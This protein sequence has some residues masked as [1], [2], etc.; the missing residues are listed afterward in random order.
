MFGTIPRIAAEL[1]L[2]ESFMILRLTISSNPDSAGIN[3][4]YEQDKDTINIHHRICDEKES[5]TALYQN[6]SEP[7]PNHRRNIHSFDPSDWDQV[8]IEEPSEFTIKHLQR[9]DPNRAERPVTAEEGGLKHLVVPANH[10]LLSTQRNKPTTASQPQQP[11]NILTR[12]FIETQVATAECIPPHKI[13]SDQEHTGLHPLWNL[14]GMPPRANFFTAPPTV[15]RSTI[16]SPYGHHNITLEEPHNCTK[17]D[18][19]VSPTTSN[20]Q[21]KRQ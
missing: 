8:H 4:R 7:K 14:T 19:N 10:F 18:K 5:V 12:I 20:D 13:S 3:N 17:E 16:E 6:K 2:T 21:V 9:G 11:W 15:T 1:N